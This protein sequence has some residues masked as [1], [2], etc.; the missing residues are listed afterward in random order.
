MNFLVSLVC[1]TGVFVVNDGL[2]C[3][4]LLSTCSCETDLGIILD[5]SPLDAG[6]GSKIKFAANDTSTGVLRRMEYNPCS[7]I[8][9]NYGV[10][11]AVCTCYSPT[12]E[13]IQGIQSTARFISTSGYSSII[14]RY[15]PVSIS[16]NFSNLIIVYVSCQLSNTIC[17]CMSIVGLHKF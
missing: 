7:G 12:S 11:A 1:L 15:F 16:Y 9:C 5:F 17:I 8:I 2:I 10:S 3:V 4:N 14:L 13:V 6:G